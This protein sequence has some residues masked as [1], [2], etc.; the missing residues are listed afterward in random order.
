MSYQR[1]RT[2]G[3][4]PLLA[5]ETTTTHSRK[6][7]RIATVHFAFV[8]TA[9]NFPWSRCWPSVLV[10]RIPLKL[11]L[12]AGQ[13]YRGVIY[14]IKKMLLSIRYHRKFHTVREQRKINSNREAIRPHARGRAHYYR[15]VA[16]TPRGASACAI[17]KSPIHTLLV[18]VSA[19]RDG[20]VASL[21]LQSV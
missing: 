17:R 3:W 19:Q 12:E 4:L 13:L 7:C 9:W 2:S 21:C 8:R 10:I 5:T 11:S 6:R 18:H 20:L 15:H 16:R 1:S 14:K